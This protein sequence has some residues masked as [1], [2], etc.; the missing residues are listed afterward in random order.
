MKPGAERAAAVEAVEC[1]NR[2]EERFLGDVLGRGGIVDDEV[3]GPVGAGPVVAEQGLEVRGRS[4]LGAAHPGTFL[5]ARSCH[6]VPTIRACARKKSIR[7]IYARARPRGPYHSARG[8]LPDRRLPER[9]HAGRCA[10]GRRRRSDRGADQRAPGPLRPRD[11]HARLAFGR[12]RLVRGRGG[13]PRE[14]AWRRPAIHLAGALRGGNARR[15]AP[16]GPGAGQD[17]RRDRHGPGPEQPGI[18]RL[19]GHPSS[20]NFFGSGE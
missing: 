19:P 7:M 9:L 11:R 14:V 13:R 1:A 20:A 4:G 18:F 3:G 6:G 12:P 5:A 16:S 10:A 8:R 2:G 17:R 15:R